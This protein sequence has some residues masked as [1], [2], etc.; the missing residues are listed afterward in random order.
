[1]VARTTHSPQLSDADISRLTRELARDIKPLKELMAE[2]GLDLESFERLTETK[3]FQTRLTEETLLWNASDP[4]TIAKRIE[5]K[6]ATMVEDCLLE[7]Y[8]LIH[9]KNQPMQA[10]VEALKWAARMAGLGEAARQ[11]SNADG[12]VKITINIAGRSLEFE[13]EKLPGNV[14]DGT[15]VDLTPEKV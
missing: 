4:L 12:Q 2:H 5:T 3:F 15:V 1:M 10:K 8:G 14:I 6:A 9:D 13:K 11:G 7:V